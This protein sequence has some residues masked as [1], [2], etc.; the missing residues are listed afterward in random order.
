MLDITEALVARTINLSLNNEGVEK[1]LSDER[2][3]VSSFVT[4]VFPDQTIEHLGRKSFA[5][6]LNKYAP[7]S[8]LFFQ[9][10]LK[11]YMGHH[12]VAFGPK[13]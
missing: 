8:S 7:P 1:E 9:A 5:N 13:Y 10:V 11:G 3:P 12:A 6:V 4:Q 2:S